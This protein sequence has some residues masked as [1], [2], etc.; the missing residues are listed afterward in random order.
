MPWYWRLCALVAVLLPL[1]CMP[2]E[3]GPVAKGKEIPPF[4]LPLLEG[5][6]IDSA[7]LRGDEPVI[8]NFWATWC[9]PCVKEIPE[10][11]ELH[12]GD[13]ARVVTIA[14]DDGGKS[15]VQPFVARHAIDYPV[16]LGDTGLFQRFGGTGIPYT[17][18]LDGDLVVQRIYRGLVTQ[19]TLERDLV[20]LQQG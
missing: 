4:K 19:R 5:G 3:T 2:L 10:L 11:K 1:A 14:L 9:G 12:R 17:L 8:L 7:S 13:G 20:R 16:L 15:I 6:S 18:V